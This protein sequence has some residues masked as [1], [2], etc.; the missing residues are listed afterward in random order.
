M[1]K[2]LSQWSFYVTASLIVEHEFLQRVN[3]RLRLPSALEISV[4][5]NILKAPIWN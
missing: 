4:E 5:I 3:L 2:W 1:E